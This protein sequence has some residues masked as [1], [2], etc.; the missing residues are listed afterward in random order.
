MFDSARSKG[1]LKEFAKN[2]TPV[3][4]RSAS[5][6]TFAAVAASDVTAGIVKNGLD[7]YGHGPRIALEMGS[8]YAKEELGNAI[9]FEKIG[10]VRTV[11]VG[12]EHAE[13][14]KN[15]ALGLGR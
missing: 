4:P 15:M 9:E 2:C 13:D 12:L 14:R 3:D 5:N 10:R 1:L 8:H 11:G 7:R 6:L